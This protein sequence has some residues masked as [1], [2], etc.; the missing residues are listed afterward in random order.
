MQAQKVFLIILTIFQ[1]ISDIWLEKR[2]LKTNF[3]ELKKLIK[4]FK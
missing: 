3:E 4:A 2:V 1:S